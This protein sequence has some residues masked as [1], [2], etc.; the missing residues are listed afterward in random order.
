M[1]DGATNLSGALTLGHVLLAA[2]VDPSDVVVLRHT[3]T[4]HGLRDRDDLTVEK[5]LDYTRHQPVGNKLSRNPPGLWVVVVADGRRRSRLLTV[6]ENHG[7]H[8]QG[9]V[10][11]GSES[12]VFD[13]RPSQALSALVGRLVIEWSGDTVNWAKSGL[14]AVDFP[15]VEIADPERVPFPGFDRVLLTHADLQA[16]ATESRYG[17]WRTALGSVQGVYLIADTST[18]RLYVGKADGEERILGRW[19][20]YAN[21][22]HGGNVA[23]KQLAGQ[24][25]DHARHYRYSVLRVFGPSVPSFDVD[26]AENHYKQA[27]LTRE[28]GL[29]RN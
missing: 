26:E 16:V 25:P 24:D 6:Y 8:R 9:A 3:Y 2:G 13:L 7:E 18:G 28:H 14:Q 5:V 21:D 27:L 15:V 19:T 23:L 4:V 17:D 12:R 29:N 11:P 22:G 1:A 10:D 20:A